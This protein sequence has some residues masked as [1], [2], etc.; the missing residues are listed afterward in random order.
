MDHAEKVGRVTNSIFLNLTVQPT[1]Q[2]GNVINR[3]FVRKL[4]FK[5]CEKP[6]SLKTSKTGGLCR[7]EFCLKPNDKELWGIV[8]WL[9]SK[10]NSRLPPSSH[11]SCCFMLRAPVLSFTATASKQKV[12]VTML[13]KK[14]KERLC[15]IC[16][17]VLHFRSLLFQTLPS[18]IVQNNM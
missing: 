2:M 1:D 13:T 16:A 12:M 18:S 15:V 8:W 11:T 14:H 9:R 4:Y 5:T 3:G 7:L 6:F 17:A 10:V